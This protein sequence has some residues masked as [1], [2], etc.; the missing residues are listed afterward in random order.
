MISISMASPNRMLQG[1]AMMEIGLYMMKQWNVC[2]LT[3]ENDFM[4]Y[5]TSKYNDSSCTRPEK[6]QI[7]LK[8]NTITL[9]VV[10]ST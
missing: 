5:N 1:A 3:P 7:N 8:T 2:V 4:K 10:Q 9:M 6:V